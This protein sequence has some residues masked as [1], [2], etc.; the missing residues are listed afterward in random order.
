MK[1]VRNRAVLYGLGF[2]AAGAL[3]FVTAFVYSSLRQHDP[4]VGSWLLTAAVIGLVIG[5]PTAD[6]IWKQ[7]FDTK[8]IE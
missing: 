1:L 8:P 5:V 6:R 7:N 3:F 4:A 2:L